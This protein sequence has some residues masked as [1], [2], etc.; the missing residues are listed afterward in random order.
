MQ[1]DTTGIVCGPHAGEKKELARELRRRMTPAE[2]A[3]WR[4][5]RRSQLD[6]LHFRRQQVIDGYIVDFYCHAAGLL[7]EVDGEVHLNQV[8]Y[9]AERD[10]V[11]AVRGLEVLRFSNR[12]VVSDT[13]AVLT[14]I[15]E[16]AIARIAALA[17][18]S[19][20]PLPC[21]GRGLGG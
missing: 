10:R 2:I 21:E 12:Q 19:R 14:E 4:R 6:G 7:V 16:R 8:D 3:L 15:R 1:I 9:D 13:E 11:L 5:L 17:T 18:E 20:L